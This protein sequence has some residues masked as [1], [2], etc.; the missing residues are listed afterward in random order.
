[1]G[2]TVCKLT[3]LKSSV[4][5][6]QNTMNTNTPKYKYKY[7]QIHIVLPHGRVTMSVNC[8]LS[9]VNK[10]KYTQIQLQ[11]FIHYSSSGRGRAALCVN[12]LFSRHH[13]HTMQYEKCNFEKYTA[14]IFY[15]KT[16]CKEFLFLKIRSME[17]ILPG[18]VG[19]VYSQDLSTHWQ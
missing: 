14:E 10:Y 15:Q 16:Q 4:K 13:S 1:M 19:L 12:L 7:M 6:Q 17:K 18:Y 5:L 3:F 8:H 11:T 2:G 9:T